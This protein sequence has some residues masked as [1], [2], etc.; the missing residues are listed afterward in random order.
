MRPLPARL[1][2][3][4]LLLLV[5]LGVHP[6]LLLLHLGGV[7]SVVA[8]LLL[9][10]HRLLT[11]ARLVEEV[12]VPVSVLHLQTIRS[13]GEIALEI[14][15]VEEEVDLVEVRLPVTPSEDRPP[16]NCKSLP[17]INSGHNRAHRRLVV[18]RRLEEVGVRLLLVLRR[19]SVL[20]VLVVVA[21]RWVLRP[22]KIASL[23]GLAGRGAQPSDEK[24][25]AM[26]FS[27][28]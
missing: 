20:T 24:N 16:S 14:A 4:L 21:S 3:P 18:R 11:P 22:Q 10:L 9:E 25:P 12:L 17:L 1:V 15:L 8:L 5:R 28:L 19:H 27:S 26:S 6:Q 23:S 13:E 7:G 2:H